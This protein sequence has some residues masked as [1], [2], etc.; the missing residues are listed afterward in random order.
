M[1]GIDQVGF[2]NKLKPGSE[3][4]FVTLEDLLKL[5]LDHDQSQV[6]K[7]NFYLIILVTE[8]TGSHTVD[9]KNYKISKGSLISIRKD[10]LQKFNGGDG[11]KGFIMLFTEEFLIQQYDSYEVVRSFQLFNEQL[12]K[13]K[14]SLKK[15]E[16]KVLMNLIGAIKNEYL[17]NHDDFTEGIIRSALQIIMLKLYRIKTSTLSSFEN[18]R[19]L[20]DFIRFQRLVEKH[21]LESKS[22]KFYASEMNVTPK[23][24]TNISKAI[25]KKTAKELIDEIVIRN[26]KRLLLNTTMSI[27]EIAFRFGFNDPSNFYAYF[28]KQVKSTPEAFRDK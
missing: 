14:V 27:K 26:A 23:T 1:N 8:G 12:I 17:A 25:I 9:F 21:Y 5:K 10:Q 6:H 28:K 22:V 16:F 7:V 13:P 11:L 3:F 19:Y 15:H 2:H 4:D 20:E 18:K 24:L